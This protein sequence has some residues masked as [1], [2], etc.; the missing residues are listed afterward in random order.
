M[1]G[2]SRP[3]KGKVNP[4]LA[5]GLKKP[6]YVRFKGNAG[7]LWFVMSRYIRK[8]EWIE[9][10]GACVDGCG[11]YIPDWRE[12][13]CGHFRASS[14]GFCTKFE[15]TNLG[16]QTKY[17][18]NPTWSP[19]SSYGFGKTIDKRYGKG[20]ADRLTQASHRVCKEYSPAE[21]DLEIK[22]YI[23]LFNELPEDV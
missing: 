21:Y 16:L 3:K 2:V 18:N 19:D 11:R 14:R 1:N 15:R 22:K 4:W 13:D 6:A 10:N 5:Y 7:I 20:T 23:R 17:C 9:Y 12:A 8:S